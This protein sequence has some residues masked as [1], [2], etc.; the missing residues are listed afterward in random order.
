[1]K[2][3]PYA[4]QSF[5]LKDIRIKNLLKEERSIPDFEE[6]QVNRWLITTT[7]DT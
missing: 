2:P 3:R 7:L 1:V 4:D 6:L 5:S